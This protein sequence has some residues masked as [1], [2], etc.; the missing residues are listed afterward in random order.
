MADRITKS[1]LRIKIVLT[2]GV[3]TIVVNAVVIKDPPNILDN[4]AT[5]RVHMINT[6]SINTTIIRGTDIPIMV[7]GAP[8]VNGTDMPG[9]TRTY[10][11]MEDIIAKAEV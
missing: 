9:S 7:T 11:N 10:T 4:P 1:G 8:G 5:G 6:A 2:T 3:G